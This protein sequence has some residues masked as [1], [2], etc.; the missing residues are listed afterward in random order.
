MPNSP[1]TLIH[2]L[3][4]HQLTALRLLDS[5][6]LELELLPPSLSPFP[7]IQTIM[8]VVIMATAAPQVIDLVM[9]CLANALEE[10][11]VAHT[12]IPDA[13]NLIRRWTR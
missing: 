3:L 11:I 1:C 10:N 12:A 9:D 7:R 6:E 4:G 8:I 2:E 5:A 13:A